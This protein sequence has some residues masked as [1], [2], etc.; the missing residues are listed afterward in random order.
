[1]KETLSAENIRKYLKTNCIGQYI[2][3][4]EELESTNLHCR[5][6]GENL[7]HGALVTALHQSA[8]KGSKGR[9]W[10]SPKGESIAMSLVL[11]PDISPVMAPR[12]TPVL[13][14]SIVKALKE[15]GIDSQIK[16][17]N[18]IVIRG[19]KLVGILTEM[20]ATMEQVRYVVIGAGINVSTDAFSEELKD[21]ATSMFLETGRI[22]AREEI[23]AGI[24]NHFER[25]YEMFL[26]TGD[27]S[28]LIEQY[29]QFSATLGKRVRVMD[30]KGEY[31]GCAVD[32]DETGQLLVQKE[33]GEMAEVFADEVSVRGIYGYV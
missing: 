17:P 12:L 28:L 8:G 27:L 3:V 24:L 18:D 15:L 26:E 7:P 5:K 6:N 16:W 19:K 4:H 25:D 10:E 11:K 22:Y 13:A 14:L 9:S 21:R 23:M 33:N 32:V 29:K 1:M 2:E 20:S 30:S 31:S